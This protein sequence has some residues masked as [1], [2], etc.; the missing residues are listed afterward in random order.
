MA[1]KVQKYTETSTYQRGC[2]GNHAGMCQFFFKNG[3][4]E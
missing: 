2:R 1:Q 3:S 4:S